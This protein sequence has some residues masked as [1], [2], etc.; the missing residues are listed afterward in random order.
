MEADSP[1]TDTDLFTLIDHEKIRAQDEEKKQLRAE[2]INGILWDEIERLN[3]PVVSSRDTSLHDDH[4]DEL[5]QSIRSD[6]TKNIES[7]ESELERD[8]RALHIANDYWILELRLLTQ[9]SIYM[10]GQYFPESATLDPSILKKT[11]MAQLRAEGI[12]SDEW[13]MLIDNV[14]TGDRL[15]ETQPEDFEIMMIAL[16]RFENCELAPPYQLY[17]RLL[18]VLDVPYEIDDDLDEQSLTQLRMKADIAHQVTEVAISLAG[19]TLQADRH[20]AI[21]E[22]ARE[23]HLDDMSLLDEVLTVADTYES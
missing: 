5:F 12:E 6:I 1:F 15:D 18:E 19:K 3:T 20:A 4:F 17:C 16:E 7:N 9:L 13:F 22:I 8:E 23:F 21:H 14:L 2:Y 10:H 11:F